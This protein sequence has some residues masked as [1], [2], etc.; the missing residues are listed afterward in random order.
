MEQL[1]AYFLS[2]LDVIEK[3]LGLFGKSVSRAVL[4]LC[5]IATGAFLIG[6]GLLML[7]WTCFTAVRGLIGPVWAG[8]L[9]AMLIFAGG[10]VC[11]WTGKKNSP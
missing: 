8:L 5:L 2:L 7:A 3:E 11:L 10:G 9:T 4:G 1:T 6:A